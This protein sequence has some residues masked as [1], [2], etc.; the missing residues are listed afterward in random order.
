MVGG[1]TQAVYA[2][3]LASLRAMLTTQELGGCLVPHADEHL[4]EY[5]PPSAERLAWLSGFTGSAGLAVVLA[6]RAALFTD[7]RYILQA[8]AEIDPT[9]WEVHHSQERPPEQW[10][11][12]AAPGARIGYDPM[13]ITESALARFSAVG[14]RDDFHRGAG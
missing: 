2:S 7:G 10:L 8:E 9:L 3:R 12:D 13:L 1:E 14:N 4:G 5:V 6:D 11:V